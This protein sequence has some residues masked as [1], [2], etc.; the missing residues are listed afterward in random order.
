MAEIS[1]TKVAYIELLEIQTRNEILLKRLSV[2]VNFRLKC[3]NIVYNYNSQI[4]PFILYVHFYINSMLVEF[5][6]DL[7]WNL[8]LYYIKNLIINI[9]ETY[10]GIKDLQIFCSILNS[11]DSG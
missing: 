9:L 11:I 1:Q 7:F 2:T 8:Y 6:I 4:V 10:E 5:I 3:E